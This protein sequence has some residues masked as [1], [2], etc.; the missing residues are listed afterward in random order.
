M[1]ISCGDLMKLL[2]R[3]NQVFFCG[4]TLWVF[5]V[6]SFSTPWYSVEGIGISY[7]TPP[8]VDTVAGVFYWNGLNLVYSPPLNN[9][10]REKVL[11]WEAM[12]D[13]MPKNV[14][15]ASMSMIILSFAVTTVL[16]L[17][18]LF[19]LVC[20][21]TGRLLNLIA[22]GFFK[23]IITSISFLNLLLLICSWS[24]FMAFNEGL[25]RADLCL[26]SIYFPA[27]RNMTDD[28]A[29]G[30]NYG[31]WCC[32]LEGHRAMG[33]GQWVWA[34]SIGWVFSIISTI[35][36]FVMF[37]ILMTIDNNRYNKEASKKAE[38][39][40]KEAMRNR[41]SRRKKFEEKDDEWEMSKRRGARKKMEE[42]EEEENADPRE[43]Q[44]K[45]APKGR[46]ARALGGDDGG[47]DD[48]MSPG[49]RKGR[50]A[51]RTPSSLMEA[52]EEDED[53]AYSSSASRG[54]RRS[55]R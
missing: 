14:Y 5:L 21:P 34:P 33:T 13:A 43:R 40:I 20:K 4:V 53:V 49:G 25:Y 36:A 12:G 16:Q 28:S 18:I 38:M 23:Y 22:C 2:R 30:L 11:G 45:G 50:K 39:R 3:E 46:S 24:A 55:R 26:G 41:S 7:L 52:D 19:G 9:T 47:D 31:L 15:M 8:Y 42:E 17:V 37:M 10:I 32:G 44:K 29:I 1:K 54:G 48:G 6:V 51:R 35:F 27:G